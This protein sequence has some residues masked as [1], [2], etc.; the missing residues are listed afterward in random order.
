M[1]GCL[2]RRLRSHLPHTHTRKLHKSR[3]IP[4]HHFLKASYGQDGEY[5]DKDFPV[6]NPANGEELC[7]VAA[8]SSVGV[9]EMI[10]RAQATFES[11]VWSKA[12][13]LTRSKVLSKLARALEARI[14][15]LARME[16]LQTGRT[17]REMNA[18]LVRLPEWL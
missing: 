4:T 8:I 10:S 7:R 5:L 6:Y 3:Y 11:G 1:V 17:I 15:D 13:S 14:P 12:P 9:K 18:Q 2:Q 16:T